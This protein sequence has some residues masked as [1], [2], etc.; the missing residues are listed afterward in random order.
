MEAIFDKDQ[1]WKTAKVSKDLEDILLAKR[2]RNQVKDMIR[3]AK[4]DFIQEEIENDE[5]STRKFWE[6]HNYVLPEGDRGNSIRLIDKDKGEIVDDDGLPDYINRFFTEIGPKLA[7]RFDDDW[8]DNIPNFH[9]EEMG[10]LEVDLQT[11]EKVVRDININKSSSTPYLSSRILKDAFM[12][13][14]PQLVFM[15]NLSFS[16][17]KFPDAW[18]I[19][20]VVPLKKEG[21]QLMLTT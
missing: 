8:T 11:M 16:T 21:T 7:D 5:L 12:V 19:A 13:M 1:A 20:N 14:L 9:E 10:N 3:R 17:G 2:L 15:Y 4:R 6:K 18:Q